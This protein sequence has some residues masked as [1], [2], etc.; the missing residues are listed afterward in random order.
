MQRLI[1]NTAKHKFEELKEYGFVKKNDNYLF[2]IGEIIVIPKENKIIVYG[3]EGA[4]YRDVAVDV[5]CILYDLIKND[6]VIK[7]KKNV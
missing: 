1:F 7:E 5:L 4:D 3:N 2:G 6:L